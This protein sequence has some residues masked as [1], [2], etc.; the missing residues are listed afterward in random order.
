MFYSPQYPNGDKGG[1]GAIV[2]RTPHQVY[3]QINLHALWDQM[4]GTYR[5]PEMIGYVAAGLHGDPRF[6]RDRL[7][8]D[9]RVR[10]FA[11]WAKESHDLAVQQAY[12]DGQLQSASEEAVRK[13]HQLAIPPLPPNYIANGEETAAR[14]A[15]LA[16][17]RTADLLNG[18]LGAQR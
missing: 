8:A 11:D 7:G 13:D 16:S 3:S 6:S 12:L 9:L 17:Y 15:V 4:L 10:G 14:R 1:N 5:S 18:N 2:L